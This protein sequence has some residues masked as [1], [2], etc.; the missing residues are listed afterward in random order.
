MSIRQI[1]R[2]AIRRASPIFASFAMVF[3][4]LAALAPAAAHAENEGGPEVFIPGRPQLELESD[5]V[6]LRDLRP[7]PESDPFLR[8]LSGP[9]WRM[10]AGLDPRLGQRAEWNTL[11][12]M[13][14]SGNAFSGSNAPARQVGGVSVPFRDPAPAFSR[15]LLITR[16]FSNSPVQ[17]EPHIAVD[18]KDSNHVIVGVIDYNFPGVSVY[19][20]FDGGETWEGPIQTRYLR[21]DLIAGGDPVIGF[22]REGNAY[23]IYIS[24]GIEEFSV[25]RFAVSAPVSAIGITTSKDGGLTWSDPVASARRLPFTELDPPGPDQRV[26][27][28]IMVPFL[29]KPWLAVGPDPQNPSRDV[30]HI[31]YTEFLDVLEVLYVDELPAFAAVEMRTTIKTVHSNDLG[32]TWTDAVPVSPTV[33]RASAGGAAPGESISQG[34]QRV[35]Q[36][37]EPHTAPDGTLYVSWLDSTDDDSQEGLAEIYIARSD[38]GG[39]SFGRPVRASVFNEPGFR[40]RT[41][42]FRYWATA[43]PRL[44]TGPGGEVYIVYG[45]LNPARPVD[46]GDIFFLR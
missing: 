42:F 36:G 45:G 18:P 16:D 24:I 2:G 37:S 8:V 10:A 39:K 11:T 41:A 27:G 9:G 15:N 46:D 5:R 22:D 1:A 32:K 30:I 34:Q 43:F 33:T 35:V 26:R 20:T 21:D 29:D 23:V 17:L 25:G 14:L 7:A 4:P 38:D 44:A 28:S 13:D 19:V 31:S 40:S 6:S 12:R 3:A